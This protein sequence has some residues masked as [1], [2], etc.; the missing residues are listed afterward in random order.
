MK[1]SM[2]FISKARW[3]FKELIHR[4]MFRPP[5]YAALCRT[6]CFS[7]QDEIR[8]WEMYSLTCRACVRWPIHIL[9]C[10]WGRWGALNGEKWQGRTSK[11]ITGMS[12]D[13]LMHTFACARKNKRVAITQKN[14]CSQSL[15]FSYDWT[16]L[17]FSACARARCH[18]CHFSNNTA[19]IVS[20]QRSC[21]GLQLSSLILH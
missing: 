17:P 6:W 15:R 16:V 19:I 9:R 8:V 4:K 11:L 3:H 10:Q 13:T 5:T 21:W 2:C 20:Y 12:N 1:Y 18:V 7:G 14:H